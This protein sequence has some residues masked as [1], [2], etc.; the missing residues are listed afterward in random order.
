MGM[1]AQVSPSQTPSWT[2]IQTTSTIVL[3]ETAV[4]RLHTGLVHLVS[5][6]HLKDT[7]THN[8]YNVL[9]RTQSPNDHNSPTDVS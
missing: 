6:Q 8:Q 2:S 9:G 1:Q 5:N 7:H 3:T 4:H